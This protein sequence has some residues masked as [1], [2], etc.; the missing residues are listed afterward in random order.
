MRAPPTQSRVG[1]PHP[2]AKVSCLGR[3]RSIRW[4]YWSNAVSVCARDRLVNHPSPVRTPPVNDLA[5][6]VSKVLPDKAGEIV[7]AATQSSGR[8]VAG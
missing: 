3:R 5:A 1:S 4:G 7:Y 6:P 2:S 8:G